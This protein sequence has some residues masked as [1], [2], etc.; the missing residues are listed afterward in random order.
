MA[1]KT[2]VLTVASVEKALQSKLENY[3]HSC[4][5]ASL[6]LVRSGLLGPTARVARGSCRGVGGQHSWAVI[7]DPYESS[8]TIVDITLWSYTGDGKEIWVWVG[9]MD[10]GLHRP[11]GYSSIFASDM[12]SRGSGKII[13]LDG[14]SPRAKNFMQA[15]GPLDAQGWIQLFNSGMLHWPSAEVISLAYQNDELRALIPIDIAGML[16]DFNPGELYR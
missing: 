12:P 16:T 7:G 13:E 2:L 15:I 6:Q 11:Q 4:H 10:N 9:S 14:M 8:S 5:A 1:A 3:Y